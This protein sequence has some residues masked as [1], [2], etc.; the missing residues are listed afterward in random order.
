MQ[1]TTLKLYNSMIY[2]IVQYQ[3]KYCT[4]GWYL[5]LAQNTTVLTFTYVLIT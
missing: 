1:N 2:K 4:H 5:Q 3:I